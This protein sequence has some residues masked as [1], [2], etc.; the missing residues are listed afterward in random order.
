MLIDDMLLENIA[1]VYTNESAVVGRRI[2]SF[3][4]GI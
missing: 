2:Y 4:I 1:R 3:N